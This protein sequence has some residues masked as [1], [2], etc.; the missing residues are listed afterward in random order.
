MKQH[1]KHWYKLFAAACGFLLLLLIYRREAHLRACMENMEARITLLENRNLRLDTLNLKSE[2]FR[3]N[4]S[5]RTEPVRT[6]P[7]PE[8]ARPLPAAPTR[9]P[10]T[11]APATDSAVTWQEPY[12]EGKFHE[13]IRIELNTADSALL[14]R[15]PG[16]GEGTARAILRYREQLGGFYSP[17]QLREK[18]TWDYA[19][20]YLDTWCNDW[21]WADEQ[22]VQKLDINRLSFKELVHHPYLNFEAVKAI[23]KWRDRHGRIQSRADLEQLGIM[24]DGQLEKLLH[25]VE[26]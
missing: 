17:E 26:F 4:A 2:V 8:A 22:L 13:V 15:V 14:V 1:S 25:Y 6:A 12:K 7:R 24:G 11:H 5:D 19:L 16:I 20:P 23:V 21:F 18:L 3:T 10:H 9:S